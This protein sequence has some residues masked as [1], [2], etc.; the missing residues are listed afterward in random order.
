ME[1]NIGTTELRQKLTDVLE[2]VRER[3]DTYIIETFG[4]SQAVIV[5]L[6]EYQQFQRFR[7]DREAFFNW[8][9]ETAA[10]NASKN[11]GLSQEQIR[12]IIN[13]ARE[14]VAAPIE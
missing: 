9:E 7:Q 6:E 2:A 1:R 13:D 5:N 14:E 10:E 3:R 11:R 4:R 8:V 12:A